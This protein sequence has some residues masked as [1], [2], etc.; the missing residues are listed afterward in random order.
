MSVVQCPRSESVFC[1]AK[2]IYRKY[3]PPLKEPYELM[4][5][6]KLDEEQQSWTQLEYVRWLETDGAKATG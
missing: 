2:L 3:A 4:Y 1:V 5:I 6:H